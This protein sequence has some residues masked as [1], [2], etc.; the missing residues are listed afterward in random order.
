[1]K[2]FDELYNETVAAENAK[3]AELATRQQAAQNHLAKMGQIG[4]VVTK[5]AMLVARSLGGLTNI[6]DTVPVIKDTTWQRLNT[7]TPGIYSDFNFIRRRAVSRLK[8]AAEDAATDAW[9]L[10]SGWTYTDYS[11]DTHDSRYGR[12]FLGV[13]GGIYESVDTFYRSSY[14]RYGVYVVDGFNTGSN[15]KR[16]QTVRQSIVQLAISSGL[17]PNL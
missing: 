11:S 13:E 15:E 8:E 1:M 10:Q 5:E 9:D 4:A 2:S 6:P 3:R 16:L 12:F 14:E 17:K 7:Q